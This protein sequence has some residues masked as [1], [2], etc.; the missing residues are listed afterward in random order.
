MGFF[1]FI[2]SAVKDVKNL[3]LHSPIVKSLAPLAGIVAHAVPIVGPIIDNAAPATE[4]IFSK[5]NASPNPGE[6]PKPSTSEQLN[7]P[8]TNTGINYTRVC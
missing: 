3:I 7:T 4:A 8:V 1:D 2:S 6:D 5:D